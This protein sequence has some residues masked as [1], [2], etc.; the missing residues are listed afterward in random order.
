MHRRLPQKRTFAPP[1]TDSPSVR[2]TSQIDSGA[3]S[4]IWVEVADGTYLPG[5]F[6][7]DTLARWSYE[8]GRLTYWPAPQRVFHPHGS[9]AEPRFTGT[10]EGREVISRARPAPGPVVGA[11]PGVTPGG[12]L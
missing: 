2:D 12:D 1:V 3:E 8:G 10:A 6:I 7:D 9:A 5:D 4:G 11:G